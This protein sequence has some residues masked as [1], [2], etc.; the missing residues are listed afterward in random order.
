M[1]KIIHDAIA[2]VFCTHGYGSYHGRHLRIHGC[3]LLRTIRNP[4]SH[5][6]RRQASRIH[7]PRLLL[8]RRLPSPTVSNFTYA[9]SQPPTSHSDSH[10][11]DSPS[12]HPDA[13]SQRRLDRWDLFV[14]PPFLPLSFS[15]SARLWARGFFRTAPEDTLLTVCCVSDFV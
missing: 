2:A 6:L 10:P 5:E 12:V 3:T 4:H 15:L 7:S 11:T 9:I 14:P 13:R 8:C 1:V